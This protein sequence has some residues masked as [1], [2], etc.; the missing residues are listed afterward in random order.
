MVAPEAG[1]R[2]AFSQARKKDSEG[3]KQEGEGR[4]P[5]CEQSSKKRVT[6]GG[7]SGINLKLHDSGS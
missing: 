7:V 4:G 2:H 5:T 3:K 1:V 6:S